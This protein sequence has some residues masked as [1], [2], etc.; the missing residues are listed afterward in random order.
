MS[1]E[2]EVISNTQFHFLNSFLVKINSRALH[3]HDEIEIGVVLEGEITLKTPP[4]SHIL[5]RGDCFLIDS[6]D[7]HEFISNDSTILS[8]Q[9][10]PTIFNAFLE[11]LLLLIYAPHLT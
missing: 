5:S 2:Y 9:I 11:I 8:I 10:S 7:S 1:K 6:M 4:T 3:L